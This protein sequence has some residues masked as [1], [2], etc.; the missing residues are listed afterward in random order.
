[1]IKFGRRE[2]YAGSGID[3]PQRPSFGEKWKSCGGFHAAAQARAHRQS[4]EA[5]TDPA[6]TP[7]AVFA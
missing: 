4:H 1:M 3:K 6:Q 7:L 2:T 5:T